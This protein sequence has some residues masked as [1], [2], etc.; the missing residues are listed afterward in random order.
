MAY[1]ADDLILDIKRRSFLPVAQRQFSNANLLTIAD[2][3]LLGTIAPKLRRL[4]QGYWL[5]AYD[6][7]LVADQRRY[8]FPRYAMWNKVNALHLV[9][10]D[11]AVVQP[12]TR[13]E[14]YNQ[15]WTRGVASGQP[16]RCWFEHDKVV[17]DPPPS[18]AAASALTL[19]QW[20]YRRPN[21]LIETSGALQIVSIAGND[22]TTTTVDS[23]VFYEG[24]EVDVFSP[25]S[26]FTRVATG[27]TLGGVTGDTFTQTAADVALLSEGDWICP[28]DRTV[29]PCLPIEMV[30]YLVSLV[31]LE[32][33][34]SQGDAEAY[35][36][37][38]EGIIRDMVSLLDGASNRADSQPKT[39]SLFNSP[40]A[41]LMATRGRRMGP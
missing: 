27:M 10:A 17:L 6:Q 28:Q 21:R 4:D 12:L 38:R 13:A 8:A 34:A 39:V 26:P 14:P 19:R 20:I 24:E 2:E 32:L 3:Q 33:S 41:K 1:T 23:D 15:R 5:E 36:V 9:D 31:V 11:G 7:A 22:V 35:R 37:A 30:P 18:S 40:L 16:T 25:N 29:F